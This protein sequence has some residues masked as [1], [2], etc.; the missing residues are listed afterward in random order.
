VLNKVTQRNK[1]T[2]TYLVPRIDDL[3]YNLGG[4]RYVSSLDLT[5]GYNEFKLVESDVQKISF[6]THIG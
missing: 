4:T 6:N 5:S 2:G 3:M 1:Y